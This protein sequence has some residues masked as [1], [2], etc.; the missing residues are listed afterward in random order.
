MGTENQ[1]AGNQTVNSAMQTVKTPVENWGPTERIFSEK[2]MYMFVASA[3]ETRGLPQVSRVLPL[4]REL[5]KGQVRRGKE[6]VPYISHPL[7]MAC[8]ALALELNEDDIISTI[9]LHDV[10]ED[11][12]VTPQELPVNETVREAVRRMTFEIRADENEET[13]RERYYREIAENRI[14]TVVKVIDRCNN[15]STMA[16]GFSKP[17]IIRYIAETEEFVMPLLKIMKY[18][19]PEFNNAAFL[20]KYQ[21]KSVL[22]SLKSMIF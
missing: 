7:M 15:I 20:I 8:H 12:N 5:H 21:M 11:C 18:N 17:Q 3:A 9:L 2:N 1:I 10:C 4:V 13:A 22:E 16:L 14:A 6:A 19:Y